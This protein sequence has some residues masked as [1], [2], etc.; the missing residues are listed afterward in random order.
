MT[1]RIRC[2]PVLIATVLL[3]LTVLLGSCQSVPT[4]PSPKDASDALLVATCV[5]TNETPEAKWDIDFQL[6]FDNTADPS[7]ENVFPLTTGSY[8]VKHLPP[9]KHTLSRLLVRARQ[10]GQLVWQMELNDAAFTMEAGVITVL[11]VRLTAV[12][13][14]NPKGTTVVYF[15]TYNLLQKDVGEVMEQLRKYKNIELWKLPA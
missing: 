8:F 6:A 2:R 13:K 10:S 9:G 11:P 14:K 12:M 7:S 3:T 5:Y 1:A 15:G 4:A